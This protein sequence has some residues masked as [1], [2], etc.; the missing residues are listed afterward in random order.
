M[1][2]LIKDTHIMF[3]KTTKI[4]YVLCKLSYKI[5]FY[6]LWPN[7]KLHINSSFITETNSGFGYYY[8]IFHKSI[9]H[10]RNNG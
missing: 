7:V 2:E 5:S 6:G 10:G 8:P 9:V 1:F 4:H 3:I